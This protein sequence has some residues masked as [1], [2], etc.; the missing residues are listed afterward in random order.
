MTYYANIKMYDGETS[1]KEFEV[2]NMRADKAL[3]KALRFLNAKDGEGILIKVARYLR[4]DVI[5]FEKQL[6]DAIHGK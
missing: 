1:R 4:S 6:M 3:A 2:G 5:E